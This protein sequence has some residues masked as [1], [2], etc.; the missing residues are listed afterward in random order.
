[1]YCKTLL[2]SAFSTRVNQTTLEESTTAVL[3]M[4]ALLPQLRRAHQIKYNT[5]VSMYITYSSLHTHGG[6]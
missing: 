2:F 6:C 1:M 3:V 5:Q 4:T